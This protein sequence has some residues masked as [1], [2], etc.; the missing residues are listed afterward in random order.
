[1]DIK[2]LKNKIET[3]TLNNDQMIWK[4]KDHNVW[5]LN[6]NE[7]SWFIAKQYI[8]QI[9][10]NKNLNIKYISNFDEVPV[11]ELIEDTNLYIYKIEELGEYKV[12]DNSI[13]I[14]T[15]TKVKSA[16]EFPTLESWQ[17]IDYIKN[18]V[19][20]I[21]IDDLEWLATQY[22]FSGGRETWM[23]YFMFYNDMLKISIFPAVEQQEV[24]NGLYSSG[25]YKTISNLT[26]FDLSN[27]ILRKDEKLALEVLKVFPYIDSKPDLWLLSILLNNFKRVIDIQLNSTLTAQDLGLSDKQYYAIKH[28]NVGVYSNE[29]LINIYQMLT[30]LEYIYKFGGLSSDQI[31]DYIVCKILGGF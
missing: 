6:T 10:K 3:N 28:N 23:R 5:G 20:G 22:N 30:N 17:F 24:F 31:V 2:E 27:A 13:I 25:E 8:N 15:K 18:I 9:A 11:S 12:V 19:P 14:C 16:I 7:S 26:I 21:N 1:M 29:E 4:I